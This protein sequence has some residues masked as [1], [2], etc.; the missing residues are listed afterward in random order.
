M[1]PNITPTK[2]QHLAWQALQDKETTV[3]VYG[4]AAGGGKSWLGC[5]WLIVMSYF[6]PGTR[7]FIGREEWKRLRSTT[8]LTFYKVLKHHKVP[9]GEWTYNGQD[10]YFQ[11]SNGS[12]IDLLDLKYLP[13]D[14][15]YERYGSEEFTGGWIEEGGEVN[16]GAYDT[17]KSRIGRY[18]NVEYGILGKI[19]ITCN[20]KKNWLYTEFYKPFKSSILKAGI[21]FIQAYV[22]DNKYLDENYI[23]SLKSITD[24]SKKERL[25]KG[26]WEYDDDPSTLCEYDAIVA[27]L[28]ND[29]VNHGT[30]Y[31]TADIARMG[32][33][34]ALIGVWSGWRLIERVSFDVSKTT[35]IQSAINNLRN[36]HAIPKY[37]CIADEDGVGGGVIDNTGVV[38][39]INNSKALNDE[40][41]YNL[42][43]QCCYKLAEQINESQIYIECELSP[44]ERE[45]IKEEMEQLKSYQSD[46]DGKLRILPKEQIKDNIGR[47]PDWRDMIMMRKY[48]D[49]NAPLQPAPQKQF[50]GIQRPST[51]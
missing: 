28:S 45:D 29:H 43:S 46:N 30:K 44:Q 1:H 10:H 51:W 7:W 15:L 22:T 25:L 18:M 8:V 5:E 49:L 9:T 33:D 36:K 17:L 13:S 20:P 23:N 48:F 38:G 16:F 50:R 39:F 21:K 6:F 4:G 31:I 24:K 26:N 42:Q 40:N 35:E 32:S 41:Y 19:L 12:R 47:S 2:K 37:H 27:I 11:C 3:V 14:P 34:K